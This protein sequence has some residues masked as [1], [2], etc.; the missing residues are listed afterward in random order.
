MIHAQINYLFLDLILS[1]KI[2]KNLDRFI[3][4]DIIMNNYV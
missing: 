2:F 3:M 4:L 1:N